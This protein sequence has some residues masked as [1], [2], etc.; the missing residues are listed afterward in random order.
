MWLSWINK[1]RKISDFALANKGKFFALYK[2]VMELKST[3]SKAKEKES[4][5]GSEL[6][7]QERLDILHEAEDVTESL[8]PVLEQLLVFDL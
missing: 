3:I 6:S 4:E 8:V 1:A 5:D 2:E 7:K